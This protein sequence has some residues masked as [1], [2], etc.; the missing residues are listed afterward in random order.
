M[1]KKHV[2]CQHHPNLNGL[3]IQRKSLVVNLAEGSG[4][5]QLYQINRFLPISRRLCTVLG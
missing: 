5:L 3:H 4:R 2:E 1:G